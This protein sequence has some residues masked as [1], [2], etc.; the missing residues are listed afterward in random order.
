ML[1]EQNKNKPRVLIVDNSIALTGAVKAAI[2]C[3]LTLKDHFD[4]LFILPT[5]SLASEYVKNRE[6]ELFEVP[7]LE[8]R[9]N[10]FSVIMYW[11]RLVANT[12]RFF[13]LVKEQRIDIIHVNDFYNMIP[14][15]YKLLGGGLPYICHARFMPD[16]FPKILIRIWSFFHRRYAFSIVAV[17]QTLQRELTYLDKIIVIG[18]GLPLKEVGYSPASPNVLLYPANFTSG[19]G[20]EYAIRSFAAIAKKYSAWKLRFIGGDMGLKKNANFKKNLAVLA[21]EEGIENQIEWKDF[22]DSMTSE[23]L[24]ASIVLNFSDSESFSLTCLEALFYGRPVIATDSGGP[25]EIID[26]GESGLI[27]PKGDIE[28]MYKALDS[29][30]RDAYRRERMALIGRARVRQRYS[31][32][33][34]VHRLRDQYLAALE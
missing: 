17:S 1:A 11:P 21:A 28:S 26:H 23:Y 29:L 4:F 6:F 24:N 12:I 5:R 14:S 33:R 34:T 27:I 18:D 25:A 13:R 8:L 9:R 15:L 3:S 20:Q 32:E 22:S 16:R 19:K 30:M 10:L 2:R 31:L 7:M